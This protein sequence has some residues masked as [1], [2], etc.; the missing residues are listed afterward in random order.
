MIA[1]DSRRMP[2]PAQLLYPDTIAA[3]RSA[4]IEQRDCGAEPIKSLSTAIQSAAREGRARNLPPQAVLIQ[5]TVLADEI[6]LPAAA[7]DCDPKGHMRE[8][9]V[10]ACLRAYWNANAGPVG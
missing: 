1:Y 2:D 5:L 3:L 4:L 7:P 9:M 10:T 8:W 6:G